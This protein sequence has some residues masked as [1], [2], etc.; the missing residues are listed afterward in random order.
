M[1]EPGITITV[2][3]WMILSIKYFLVTLAVSCYGAG[4]CLLRIRYYPVFQDLFPEGRHALSRY[5]FYPAFLR[6][7]GFRPL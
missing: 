6:S 2:P 7:D 1:G 4:A 5:G 3:I